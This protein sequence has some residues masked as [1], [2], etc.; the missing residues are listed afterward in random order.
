MGEIAFNAPYIKEIQ[1]S[2]QPWKTGS[3]EEKVS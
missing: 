1:Y 2:A 3:K